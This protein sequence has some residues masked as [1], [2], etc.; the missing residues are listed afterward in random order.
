MEP[1]MHTAQLIDSLSTGLRPVDPRSVA[2]EIAPS[3]LAGAA[4]ALVAVVAVYG[5]Q[6]DLGTF[7][8][9]APFA[10]KVAYAGT[11]GALALSL[12]TALA[13]PGAT[14][15]G[16]RWM[17][18]PIAL[19]ALLA[20]AQLAA[21]DPS[22]WRA[23]MLGGSWDRC[24]WRIVMLAVPVFAGLVAAVR[25]QAPTRLRRAGAAIGLTAGATAASFY[26]LACTEASAAFVLIWYSLGIMLCGVLGA[27]LGPRLLRW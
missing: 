11:V 17:L 15:G 6:P 2:R 3:L 21:V 20:G 25:R 8:H 9:G 22:Q 1:E 19:L 24:P 16:W 13:R 23:L 26:A 14:I 5:V 12:A 7:A 27:L 4:A 10:M 18:A